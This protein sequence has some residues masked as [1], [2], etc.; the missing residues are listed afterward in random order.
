M[1]QWKLAADLNR[2]MYPISG[3]SVLFSFLV[4]YEAKLNLCALKTSTAFPWESHFPL[5]L[6]QSSYEGHVAVHLLLLFQQQCLLPSQT[7]CCTGEL[8]DTT[9][10]LPSPGNLDLSCIF[11][12]IKQSILFYIFWQRCVTVPW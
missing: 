12:S 8:L 3:I 5:G 1:K 9:F 7:S 2:W 6:P 11:S 10:L 4:I